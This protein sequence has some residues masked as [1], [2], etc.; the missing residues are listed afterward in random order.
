[1]FI[2]PNGSD[3]IKSKSL[4]IETET[5]N[6][7]IPESVFISNIC[8]FQG[9]FLFGFGFFCESKRMILEYKYFA[10]WFTT[11][12]LFCLESLLFCC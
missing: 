2:S 3:V 4:C 7:E 11:N 9:N 5:D 8:S 1:M 6:K 12:N 10:S